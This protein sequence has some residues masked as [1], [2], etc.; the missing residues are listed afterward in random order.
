MQVHANMLAHPPF[1][2]EEVNFEGKPFYLLH[3]TYPCHFD[4]DGNMTDNSTLA[5]YSFDKRDYSTKPPP[6]NLPEPPPVRGRV[7]ISRLSFPKWGIQ[8]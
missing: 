6:R 2:R 7:P 8:K 4:K 5:I 1:D 3:L